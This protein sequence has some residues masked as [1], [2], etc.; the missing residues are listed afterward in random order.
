MGVHFLGLLLAIAEPSHRILSKFPQA[1]RAALHDPQVTNQRDLTLSQV[2]W[3][4]EMWSSVVLDLGECVSQSFT[5][6]CKYKNS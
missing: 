1:K 4:V 2:E 6:T 5:I 3:G